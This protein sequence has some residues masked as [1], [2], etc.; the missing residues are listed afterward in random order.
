MTS[1]LTLGLSLA[2][3]EDEYLFTGPFLRERIAIGEV[4]RREGTTTLPIV[5]IADIF[6]IN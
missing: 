6:V 3:A 4:L 5:I 2:L 1:G